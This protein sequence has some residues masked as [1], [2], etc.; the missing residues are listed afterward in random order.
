[1]LFVN[2]RSRH[3]FTKEDK[4]AVNMFAHLAAVTIRNRDLFEREQ[5]KA[6]TEEALREAARVLT[7][8]RAIEDSIPLDLRETL[9]VIA[10]QGHKVADACG[11][12]IT[13][14]LVTLVE[15]HRHV[16]FVTWPREYEKERR[17]QFW[18]MTDP[19]DGERSFVT[20]VFNNGVTTLV[21]STTISNRSFATIREDTLSQLVAAIGNGP[22]RTGVIVV[23]SSNAYGFEEGTKKTFEF[24]AT[25]ALDAIRTARQRTD[26][27]NAKKREKELSDLAF[28]YL[29]S[30]VLVHKH[31]GDVREFI[32]WAGMLRWR[33]DKD[34]MSD[35]LLEDFQAFEEAA[36]MFNDLLASSSTQ[37]EPFPTLDL[38]DFLKDWERRLREDRTYDA[39]SISF[40][41]DATRGMQV[42]ADPDLLREVLAI[43][44]SN[45]RNAMLD[46]S[47]KLLTV[48]TSTLSD[49]CLVKFTDTGK[50]IDA[51]A[52]GTD[53]MYLRTDSARAAGTG[54]G[55]PTAQ[56][57]VTRFGGEILRPRTSSGGTTN[58][59]SL[60]LLVSE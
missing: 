5:R 42:R 34:G 47:Q 33:A 29:K 1:M 12:N 56:L 15:N 37:F 58:T 32:K 36:T 16:M 46:S 4:D 39:V 24:F 51:S 19:G 49:Q 54:F 6:L 11:R 31:K 57:I 40:D 25:L 52:L 41:I 14:V 43:L 48:E 55:I 17:A 53:G 22:Q 44:C 21:S 7:E 28:F 26:L 50:G 35:E 8:P 3:T 60:P 20:E 9:R 59:F 10:D 45:A 23:E 13:S 2:Y 38:N 27:L 18:R 30:G